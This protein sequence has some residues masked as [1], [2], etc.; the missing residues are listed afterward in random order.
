MGTKVFFEYIYIII[1]IYLQ[2]LLQHLMNLFYEFYGYQ[3]L[4]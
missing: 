4:R 3:Y 1:S 2:L